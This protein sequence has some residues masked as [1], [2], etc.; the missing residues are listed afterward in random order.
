MSLNRSEEFTE[1][2][3]KETSCVAVAH[4]T[5]HKVLPFAASGTDKMDAGNHGI[6]PKLKKLI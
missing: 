6:R 2:G 5:T 3:S 1:L 4:I